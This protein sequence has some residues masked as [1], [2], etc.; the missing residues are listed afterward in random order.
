MEWICFPTNADGFGESDRMMR[1]DLEVDLNVHFL[2]RRGTKTDEKHPGKYP[3]V[4]SVISSSNFNPKSFLVI[5]D[6]CKDHRG[7]LKKFS[8]ECAY[9][10][11]DKLTLAGG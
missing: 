6:V 3:S 5:G 1:R 10:V 9:S 8:Q 4:G 11:N 7:N 2:R